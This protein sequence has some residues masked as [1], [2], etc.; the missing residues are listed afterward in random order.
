MKKIVKIL[1]FFGYV[2]IYLWTLVQAYL[3]SLLWTSIIASFI[4]AVWSFIKPLPAYIGAH[5]G[6]LMLQGAVPLSLFFL[7][8]ILRNVKK[9]TAKPKEEQKQ[10]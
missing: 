8:Y 2:S 4:C 1:K 5:Y 6:V 7:I 10:Q 9:Q 3:I